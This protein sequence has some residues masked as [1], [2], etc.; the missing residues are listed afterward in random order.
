MGATFR[1]CKKAIAHLE[2]EEAHEKRDDIHHHHCCSSAYH[3]P[4]AH[5]IFPAVEAPA[6][7]ALDH[8]EAAD[9]LPIPVEGS[10]PAAVEEDDLPT[11]IVFASVACLYFR[12]YSQMSDNIIEFKFAT[13]AVKEAHKICSF[14]DQ[15]LRQTLS[16]I[17]QH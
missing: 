7:A 12:L 10:A 6:A 2:E 1:Q 8:H 4:F 17:S 13:A 15:R 5:G 14:C 9:V 16:R 3:Y 11:L